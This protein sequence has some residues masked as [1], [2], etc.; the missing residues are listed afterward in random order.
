MG[1]LRNM[2]KVFSPS[3]WDL[4]GPVASLIKISSRGL[5][6][7]DRETFIKRAGAA[8]NIFLP[9]LDSI[10]IAADEVPVH[11]IGVCAHETWSFN[12]NGDGWFRDVLKKAHDTFVKM[13]RPYRSH[14]NKDPE[15]SYGKIKL[16]AYNDAM[17]RV[18]LL[19]AYNSTKEAAER[20]GGLIAD[21][22]IEKLARDGNLPVSM[23]CA[24]PGT[25]VK[26]R[27]GFVRV[28][29][30]KPGDH[31][32]T[33]RGRFRR[34]YATMRRRRQQFARI[35]TRFCGRQVV[36][37]TPDHKFW[38]VRWSDLPRLGGNS[39]R[40]KDPLGMSR[41]MRT[42]RRGELYAHAHY[43]PCGDLRPGDLLLMPIYRG[44]NSS[45][46]SRDDARLLGYYTAEGSIGDRDTAVCFTCNV[47]DDIL[48][49]L[50]ALVSPEISVSY[51]RHSQS[52]KAVNAWVRSR[53]LVDLAE[54]QVGR[55]VRNKVIPRL[56][57]DAPRDI[58][59]EYMAAWFNG[60][61]WQDVKGMHWSTC[62]R[63]LSLELQ[64]LLASVDIPAS[65]Y[66][67]DHTSN[68]PHGVKRAGDGVEYTVN[69]S[70]RYSGLFAGRS[71]AEDISLQADKT[72]AF[73]TGDFLAVPVKEVKIVEREVEV[74]DLS[75]EDDES[76]TV[77]GL[78]VSNC[79]VP[80]DSCSY[81]GNRARTRAEYCTPPLCKAGGCKDNL[82]KLVKVGNDIVHVG[83]FN[84][85][86][87]F[88]DMSHVFRPA[89]YTAYGSIADYLTKAAADHGFF[90]IGGAKIAEDLGVTAPAHLAGDPL[91]VT[92]AAE[93]L[94]LANALA[95]MEKVACRV[96][97]P[98]ALMAFLPN[99]RVS[100]TG[101]LDRCS[102]E[103]IGS[104]L[105]A[106]ADDDIILPLRDFAW[107]TKRA[108]FAAEA[109]G[110]LPGIYGRLR[111]SGELAGCL[112]GFEY[113]LDGRTGLGDRADAARLHL[114]F[115]LE[116][117]AVEK[118]AR[119]A[120][121]RE[122][123]QQSRPPLV[124]SAE[125]CS[126]EAVSLA[127]DYAAYQAAA[128]YRISQRPDDFFTKTALAL[129]QNSQG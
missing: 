62:S 100:L 119:M 82:T 110:E 111:D 118:R 116:K 33:H 29:A 127:R 51:A 39:I 74:Y 75:V 86:P 76:F 26:T 34:V 101:D 31:V 89:E 55:G 70:N 37:M 56:I 85:D 122:P 10:K 5:I 99:T 112:A 27:R 98:Q 68:L 95:D 57:Y 67:I 108:A 58:K 92:A 9:Y 115:S 30:I 77:F 52:D 25:L 59:L 96:V 23:A 21:K 24:L 123:E 22:E 41:P 3:G 45:T 17:D 61:G 50:P 109:V 16:S 83:V 36:E 80:F 44:D 129:L 94:R 91:W 65:I 71:R 107:L 42:R 73:I 46:L 102:R 125:A 14:K 104:A 106:L 4:D 81:C 32:L 78:A 128:L 6:G 97:A 7:S 49:E 38:A 64:M 13:A 117:Q 84:P 114:H 20:N 90:G 40:S 53:S 60:D 79:R 43:I 8:S 87:E 72:T 69:V 105:A 120:A 88:F 15:K 18:E 28:E 35:S 124:K 1:I 113:D 66:R 63:S 121:L 126:A 54:T 2:V 19:V 103:K 47:L 93:R 48:N 12:R 11:M